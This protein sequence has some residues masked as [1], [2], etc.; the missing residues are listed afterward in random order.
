MLARR[1]RL[2]ISLLSVLA[3]I[4]ASLG[5][6][7]GPVSGPATAADPEETD[8]IG[9]T[10]TWGTSQQVVSEAPF[11]ARARVTG[12]SCPSVGFCASVSQYGVVRTAPGTAGPWTERFTDH[13]LR[14]TDI[15][16]ATASFCLAVSESGLMYGSDEPATESSW[17]VV[18]EQDHALTAV[19]C[20]TPT[21]CAAA[22]RGPSGGGL[23]YSTDP[24]QTWDVQNYVDNPPFADVSC[25][26]SPGTLC[27]GVDGQGEE[28]ES[29]SSPGSPFASWSIANVVDHHVTVSCATPTSC[30]GRAADSTTDLDCPTTSL[31]VEIDAA[32]TTARRSVGGGSFTSTTTHAEGM[33]AVGCVRGGTACVIG[34]T[35]GRM[36]STDDAAAPTATWTTS[37]VREELNSLTDVDC[38]SA[39]ACVAVDGTGH[40]LSSSSPT[41]GASAWTT[42]QVNPSGRAA[43]KVDCPT[44]SLCVVGYTD[45]EIVTVEDPF[46]ARTA[47]VRNVAGTATI[48]AV[49]CPSADLCVLGTQDDDLI[50]STAP[51]TAAWV[52]DPIVTD[53]WVSVVTCRTTTECYA[54]TNGGHIL[55]ST[56]PATD[57][58]FYEGDQP[59]TVE[60]APRAM[61]CSSATR[62][63]VGDGGG[64][65]WRLNPAEDL[66]DWYEVPIAD[67]PQ[68]TP[69]SRIFDIDCSADDVCVAASAGY[70]IAQA[71]GLDGDWGNG[72]VA[73]ASSRRPTAFQGV[74][75]AGRRSASPPTSPAS[76]SPGR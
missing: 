30:R 14:F 47:T 57:D 53:D 21:L 74:A 73:Q 20:A 24:L 56:D 71:P 62:C 7:V 52:V 22:G 29:I 5:V 44:V 40:L 58:W 72:A 63:L 48:R 64:H 27:K 11:S 31:C 70:L 6:L 76:W 9:E 15:S 38:L 16:C 18:L 28:M 3:V 13:A 17:R 2:S 61:T 33:S 49:S 65:V 35:D 69:R 12:V 41:E 51:T 67:L 50:T 1:T 55:S 19:S 66:L 8:E 68:D 42:T 60:W 36:I 54:V 34:T 59:S 45:G 23:W 43:Q 32:G 46:G 37:G 10:V 4:V 26:A 25:A 39:T 75:C